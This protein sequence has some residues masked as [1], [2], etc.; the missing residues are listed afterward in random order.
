MAGISLEREQIKLIKIKFTGAMKH[1][2][3]ALLPAP[4]PAAV[5]T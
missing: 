4:L 2:H 3:V 5:K 1:M